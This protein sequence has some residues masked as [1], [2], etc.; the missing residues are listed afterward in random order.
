MKRW[1]LVISPLEV[2]SAAHPHAGRVSAHIS[3]VVFCNVAAFI[4]LSTLK[5]AFC[6]ILKKLF[7]LHR[8]HSGTLQV[9]HILIVL[10]A[11]AFAPA[12]PATLLWAPCWLMERSACLLAARRYISST[13]FSMH[14]ALHKLPNRII[15]LI[16]KMSGGSPQSGQDISGR[17]IQYFVLPHWDLDLWQILLVQCATPPLLTPLMHGG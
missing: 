6:C 13:L 11:W 15:Q 9:H 4:A 7:F 1:L 3:H 10:D 8:M 12:F 14:S 17:E 5:I 2:V 16:S